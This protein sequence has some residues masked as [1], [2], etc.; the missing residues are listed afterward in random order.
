M[1]IIKLEDS[2]ESTFSMKRVRC[3]TSFMN[4]ARCSLNWK[5]GR[6]EMKQ[7]WDS[8]LDEFLDLPR[9]ILEVATT[10]EHNKRKI[11]VVGWSGCGLL[12]GGRNKRCSKFWLFPSMQCSGDVEKSRQGRYAL[13]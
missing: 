5:N 11:S 9:H 2:S 6:H 1:S 4:L 12:C 10:E 13:E 8:T 7:L 3:C